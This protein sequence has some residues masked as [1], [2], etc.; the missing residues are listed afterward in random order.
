MIKIAPSLLAADFTALG[1]AVARV[2]AAGAD[3]LHLDIMDGHFV[4]NISFGPGVVRAVKNCT[5]LPL[6]VH[7]MI[8]E[9]DK[10]LQEFAAAGADI[11]SVHVEACPHLHRTLER[12]RELGKIPAVALNP[13]TPLTSLEYVWDL[14]GMILIMSVNPGFGGQRFI[15][16]VLPKIKALHA[17]LSQ[18]GCDI[19]IEVDGGINVSTACQVVQ[20][21]AQILVAGS[22]VFGHPKPEVAIQELK[23]TVGEEGGHR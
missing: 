2:E 18:Q 16:A 6:D 11:I 20:A 13:A 1:A 21:G 19:P 7:L 4:P 14:T 8:S 9:P 12:I 22:A 23:A 17:K 15:P 3:L 10:Y 5:K